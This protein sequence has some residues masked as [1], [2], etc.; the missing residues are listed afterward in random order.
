MQSAFGSAFGK[1][2]IEAYGDDI[3]QYAILGENLDAITDLLG[4]VIE[5]E[6]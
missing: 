1:A 3:S 5:E 6:Y 4:N 2:F